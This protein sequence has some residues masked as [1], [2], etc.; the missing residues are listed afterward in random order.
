MITILEPS[1]EIWKANLFSFSPCYHQRKIQIPFEPAN[2]S[3][4]IAVQERKQINFGMITST[5]NWS[6]RKHVNVN[7][8]HTVQRHYI[9]A[10]FQRGFHNSLNYLRVHC[11]SKR[12]FEN[13]KTSLVNYFYFDTFRPI[14]LRIR[15]RISAYIYCI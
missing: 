8:H 7:T 14:C 1:S 15:V 2:F 5:K 9:G 4:V 6:R 13:W 10:E 3:L 11:S 12:K